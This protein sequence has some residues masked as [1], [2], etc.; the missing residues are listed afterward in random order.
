MEFQKRLIFA[1]FISNTVSPDRPIVST[2]LLNISSL[3]SFDL[4]QCSIRTGR[5]DF[6]PVPC[7]ARFYHQ[8][9]DYWFAVLIKTEAVV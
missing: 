1:T 7:Y 2:P 6:R 9:V 5:L 3:Y 4:W 8:T